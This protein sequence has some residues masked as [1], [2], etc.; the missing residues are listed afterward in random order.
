MKNEKLIVVG[1]SGSGKDWLIR[2][3][4]KE[5][6]TTSI[7]VTTRPRRLHEIEG[8]T[9]HFKSLDEFNSLLE[10]NQF[11][12][13]QDFFNDKKELWKY[14]VLKEDFNNAQA[15]IMTPGEISQIDSETRKGCFVV[16]LDIDRRIREGRI[17]GRNDNNDS[18]NRRLD[19]D[20]IDFKY[21]KDYDLKITDPEF[22]V[23]MVISLMF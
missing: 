5:G 21:F 15:F 6:L 13:N 19:A 20:E 7:K 11:I 2:Q 23:D 10:S 17:L 18:V 12:V 1:K 3:L 4:A 22:E 14:G 8:K 9:Y 16:Y